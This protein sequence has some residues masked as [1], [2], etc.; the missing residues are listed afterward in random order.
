MQFGNT[1]A[2]HSLHIIFL[3]STI[4]SACL[5][6]AAELGGLSLPISYPGMRGISTLRGR[7]RGQ[8]IRLLICHAVQIDAK[9][10]HALKARSRLV[11]QASLAKE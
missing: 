5:G 4:G 11:R 8:R 10:L 6:D 9:V 1:G 7:A 3:H 2:R